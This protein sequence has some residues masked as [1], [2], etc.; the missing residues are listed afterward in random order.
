M[1]LARLLFGAV[2]AA[3]LVCVPSVQAAPGDGI[4]LNGTYTAFSD[5][6]WAKTN[7][8]YHDERSVTQTW[9][10][11]STCA[12]FQECTGTVSSDQGWTADLKYLSGSWILRHT[13]DNWEPCIDGTATPGVQEF[14]FWKGY[15]EAFPMKGWDTTKGPS[16][17]CG[18]NKVLN[19]QM[20]FTLT[21]VG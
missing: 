6:V 21:P 13:V 17:A 14:T 1:R 9:T 4:V 2:V 8:S 15:P 12:T 20:P 10:I 18:F 5:G 3:P 7:A 11:T 19:V 16:G